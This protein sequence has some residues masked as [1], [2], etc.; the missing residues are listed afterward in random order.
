MSPNIKHLQKARCSQHS[1]SV[2]FK[3]L[4]HSQIQ[5]NTVQIHSQIQNKKRDI[6]L[7]AESSNY[8]QNQFETFDLIDSIPSPNSAESDV[9]E[10]LVRNTI[11]TS[12]R[13]NFN[14]CLKDFIL[15][16]RAH[17]FSNEI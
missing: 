14:H 5:T 6:T 2:V 1:A 13:G 10:F 3:T 12:P 11:L 16:K 8:S 7:M 4:T 9:L 17:I 15:L